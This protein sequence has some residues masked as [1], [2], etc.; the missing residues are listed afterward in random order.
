MVLTVLVF[1]ASGG[2]AC[3]SPG[4][5]ELVVTQPQVQPQELPLGVSEDRVR[6]AW[7]PPDRT[8]TYADE[9]S[10]GERTVWQY[11]RFVDTNGSR[12][13]TSV[14]FAGGRAV[15]IERTPLPR[16]VLPGGPE[17]P[18]D[19]AARRDMER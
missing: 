1:V 6:A 18:R 12:L 9:P 15:E 17:A 11:D 8:L 3:T 13:L 7:G 19:S 10:G 5:P 4:K 16:P 2:L 14:T